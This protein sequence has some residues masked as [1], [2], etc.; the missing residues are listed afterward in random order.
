LPARFA[1]RTGQAPS[2]GLAPPRLGFRPVLNAFGAGETNAPSLAR[3]PHSAR[4]RE[5]P[6]HQLLTSANEYYVYRDGKSHHRMGKCACTRI[7]ENNSLGVPPLIRRNRFVLRC[8]SPRLRAGSDESESLPNKRLFP[9]RYRI[10]I[11]AKLKATHC[12]SNES[13]DPGRDLYRPAALRTALFFERVG[14]RQNPQGHAW[15][16]AHCFSRESVNARSD[17]ETGFVAAHST[18]NL[19]PFPGV[20]Q[21]YVG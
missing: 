2:A 16:E 20:N 8:V 12:F 17:G 15:S 14:P 21:D 5:R 11:G 4:T 7:D 18:A 19:S 1:F 13:V 3:P 6:P 10:R 9:I